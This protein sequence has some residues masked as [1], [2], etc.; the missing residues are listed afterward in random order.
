VLNTAEADVEMGIGSSRTVL[1]ANA[2]S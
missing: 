1:N 2:S